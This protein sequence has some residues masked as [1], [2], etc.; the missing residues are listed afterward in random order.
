MEYVGFS[1]AP[2]GGE[3]RLVV[4]ARTV[5]ARH[6]ARNQRK[7]LAVLSDSLRGM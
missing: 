5:K 7:L 3:Q 6:S 1:V 4:D 2:K